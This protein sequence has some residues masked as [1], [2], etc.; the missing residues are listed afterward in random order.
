MKVSLDPAPVRDIKQDRDHQKKDC[1]KTAFN[2]TEDVV[3]LS[4]SKNELIATENRTAA[5]SA[6]SDLKK[7]EQDLFLLQSRML[8][9]PKTASASHNLNTDT[10]LFVALS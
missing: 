10:Q 1:K 6:L 2:A 4:S 8:A 9:D 3:T 7:I 5:N